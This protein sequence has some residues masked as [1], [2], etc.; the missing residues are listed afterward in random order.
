[1]SN[2][3]WIYNHLPYLPARSRRRFQLRL[4]LQRP[5]HRLR[6]VMT[7]HNKGELQD[8]GARTPL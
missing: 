4:H 2:S 1:M 7:K 8:R 6:L 3:K 5:Q